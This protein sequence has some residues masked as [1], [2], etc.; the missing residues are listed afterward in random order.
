[1][2]VLHHVVRVIDS[3]ISTRRSLLEENVTI[4]ILRDIRLPVLPGIILIILL[5]ISIV[6]LLPSTPTS[7]ALSSL[8]RLVH[9]IKVGLLFLLT[10]LLA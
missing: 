10:T 8:P 6:D 2:I 7:L 4:P 9:H 5:V 1:M 3:T